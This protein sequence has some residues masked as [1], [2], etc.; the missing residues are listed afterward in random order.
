[1]SINNDNQTI[2]QSNAAHIA[3]SVGVQKTGNKQKL[4][5]I[6]YDRGIAG[7]S[8]AVGETSN[9]SQKEKVD[10]LTAQ[11]I[12]KGEDSCRLSTI[13]DQ[14]IRD[15]LK[16]LIRV[17][18]Q[19]LTTKRT[20]DLYVLK[21]T[22]NSFVEKIKDMEEAKEKQYK[23][24]FTQALAGVIGGAIA[25]TLGGVGG[26]L[27]IGQTTEITDEAGKAIGGSL[28]SNLGQVGQTMSYPSQAVSQLASSAGT[29]AANGA[30]RE[31]MEADIRSTAQDQL[32][33]ILRK[34]Q[35][36]NQ[37]LEKS[38]FEYI[39]SLLSMIQQLQQSI[40]QTEM[41]IVQA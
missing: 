4:S 13:G 29:M 5:G 36:T 19:M 20:S 25:T 21:Q 30:T 40:R 3:G 17:F 1:M 32:Q 39:T 22:I 8:Y 11:L 2:I 31:K 41:G 24:S 33:E 14:F 38:V 6:H 16:L 27:Q 26:A 15:L 7:I 9:A 18:A 23:S 34:A 37:S 10:A 35:D 12:Q 28:T